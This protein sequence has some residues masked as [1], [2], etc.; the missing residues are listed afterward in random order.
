MLARLFKAQQDGYILGPVR[1]ALGALL[2]IHAFVSAQELAKLGYFGDAFHWPYLPESFVPPYRLYVVI[3]A[4]RLVTAV[5]VLIGHRARPALALAG[6]LGLYV[7]LCDRLQFHHNRYSLALF[8]ILLSLTPCDRSFVLFDSAVVSKGTRIGPFWAVYLARVQVAI[9]YVASG[10]SKLLDPDWRTGLVIGDR[11]HRY[12]HMAIERGVPSSIIDFLGSAEA[13]SALAKA[14]ILSELFLAIGLFLPRTRAFALWWGVM[15]HLTIQVTSYVEIFT[16]LML[17]T[18][19]FFVT[20][21]VR[22]RKL[23]YDPTRWKGRALGRIVRFCDWF[24]RFEA[25]PWEPDDLKK[26]RS[27]VVIRR[28]GTR[29]TGV[30]A[31]AMVARCLPPFFPLWAPLALVASFTKGGETSTGA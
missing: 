21:D 3:V 1:A 6:A 31:V 17:T 8:A 30:R 2:F 13:A 25:R 27:I 5:L 18:Y 29:A 22:A 4:A 28:D 9:V 12:G 11:I 10:G 24:A 14:A 15:F 7:I 19:G 20:P 23:F 26:G 16:L